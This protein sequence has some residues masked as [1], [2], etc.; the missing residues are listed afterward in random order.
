MST[1][2]SLLTVEDLAST[3]SLRAKVLAGRDGLR[4]EVLWAHSCEMPAPEQWLGPHELLMTVGLCVPASPEDQR[5]FIGRLDDAGLAGLMLGDHE[6]APPVSPEMLAEADRRGFPVLLT[7][8]QTP[9][10][11]VARHVAAASS[12]AQLQ[13]VLVLSKLY[14]ITAN[15]DGDAETLVHDIAV[16]LGVG[17]RIVETVTGITLIESADPRG[18][19]GLP[20]P[21]GRGERIEPAEHPESAERPERRYPLRGG[22]P[23]ELVILEYPGEA[24]DSFVLVHLMKILEVGVDRV[25]TAVNQRV[26]ASALAMRRLLGGTLTAEAEALLGEYRVSGGF[27]VAAF[28]SGDADLIA[29][30]IALRRLPVLVG[31]GRAHHL[32]LIPQD[33]V[34]EARRLAEP[35]GVRFGVSSV[36]SDS[37]DVGT[38]A[39][40]ATRAL[41]TIRFSERLWSEFEGTTISVLTRSHREAEEIIA[42]V[43]GGLSGESQAAT[44]LRETL[45]AYLRNDRHWQRTA[46]ELGIH[47]QTLSYRLGRIE[48]E[49]G[50]SVTRSADLSA[51]WIAY[52]AWESTH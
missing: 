1:N 40:E 27:Q 9:Y 18:A 21:A 3:A 37:R 39:G 12:S 8:A 42:G 6:I 4:R 33:F 47:R 14:Q 32:A 30:S 28:P 52:Q 51:F 20:D 13:Q 45:F 38:A 36:F 19:A 26:E 2:Q 29:R 5:D 41:A 25:L 10:A 23:A 16:L 43:I 15:A 24:L 49:T 46:D 44:R 35:T 22:H 17:I 48:Q 11:V 34:A 50:L 7:D 31:P